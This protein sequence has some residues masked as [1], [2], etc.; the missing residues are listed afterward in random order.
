[1]SSRRRKSTKEQKIARGR[2]KINIL[3]AKR[4]P[5]EI[6]QLICSYLRV[7][8]GVDFVKFIYM[9]SI[10]RRVA[11]KSCFHE[12][13]GTIVLYGPGGFA[14]WIIN[15]DRGR[16]YKATCVN[17]NRSLVKTLY[18]GKLDDSKIIGMEKYG[19]RPSITELDDQL[20]WLCSRCKPHDPEICS[21]C[22][23]RVSC[24]TCRALKASHY[25]NKNL[26]SDLRELFLQCGD[27]NA[28][29]ESIYDDDDDG[30]SLH[31]LLGLLLTQWDKAYPRQIYPR[32]TREKELDDENSLAWNSFSND[33]KLRY[34]GTCKF[35]FN[36]IRCRLH[37]R[38][39]DS[40][41]A[42]LMYPTRC[43][44]IHLPSRF[45]NLQY[46]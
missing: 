38:L 30:I 41:A 27:A 2:R 6:V 36:C 26:W 46:Q 39:I 33:G 34:C 35:Q 5:D 3:P 12:F 25:H 7:C 32:P 17:F 28:V 9:T 4:L 18:F 29:L 21:K 45:K 10:K 8:E 44:N 24:N 11:I 15:C 20:G 1:M 37:P 23:C 19:S 42:P 40:A 14:P 16:I 31:Y 22:K 43:S 13:D